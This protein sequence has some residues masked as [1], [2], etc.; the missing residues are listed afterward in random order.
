MSAKIVEKGRG[1]AGRLARRYIGGHADEMKQN[2]EE[3][4][5][6]GAHFHYP[7][8]CGGI[9]GGHAVWTG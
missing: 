7:D 1:A 3:P 4:G 6:S 8:D 9:S 2:Y 5:G